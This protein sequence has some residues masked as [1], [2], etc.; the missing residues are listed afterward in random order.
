MKLWLVTYKGM[1]GY[2]E[3]DSFVVRAV[4]A[5]AARR[6]VEKKVNNQP[7]GWRAREL[8]QCG[9]AEIVLGSFHAA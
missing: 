6:M 4:S 1:A 3:W 5:L 2:D 9:D 8:H 7:K